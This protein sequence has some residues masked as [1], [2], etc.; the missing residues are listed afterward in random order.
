MRNEY[1]AYCDG[2]YD[3]AEDSG[4]LSLLIGCG[5]TR[6]EAIADFLDRMGEMVG[7]LKG[8]RNEYDNCT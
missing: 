4:P 3:G 5:D 6:N 8:D 7:D 1:Q 2:C